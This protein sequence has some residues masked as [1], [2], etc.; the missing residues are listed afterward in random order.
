[1][2]YV[3]LG[4]GLAIDIGEIPALLDP[5]LHGKVDVTGR[6]FNAAGNEEICVH[7]VVQLE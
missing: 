7:A 1:M 6:V 3:F 2:C 5:F 4:P